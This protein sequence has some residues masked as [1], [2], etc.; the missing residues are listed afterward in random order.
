VLCQNVW[1]L[2]VLLSLASEGAGSFVCSFRFGLSILCF[3]VTMNLYAQRIAMS[4]AIV[5]MVNHTAVVMMRDAANPSSSS[6]SSSIGGFNLTTAT[7]GEWQKNES[8][9]TVELLQSPCVVNL[10]DS[11]NRSRAVVTIIL[12]DS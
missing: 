10:I 11:G 12:S 2:I 1:I 8:D 6:S 4:V 9:G 3:L 5:C 7:P